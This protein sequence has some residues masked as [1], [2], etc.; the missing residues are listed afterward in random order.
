MS[1]IYIIIKKHNGIVGE[2]QQTQYTT[3]TSEV[4]QKV[5]RDSGL[6]TCTRELKP[7]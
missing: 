2:Q 7:K 4:L 3:Y 6:H 5:C 1:C